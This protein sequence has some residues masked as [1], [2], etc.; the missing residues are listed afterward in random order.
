MKQH[1]MRI[2]SVDDVSMTYPEATFVV[3]VDDPEINQ[4]LIDHHCFDIVSSSK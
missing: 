3:E 2:T 1:R 4:F